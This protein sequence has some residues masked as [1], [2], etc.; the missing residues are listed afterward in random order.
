[1]YEIP[2]DELYNHYPWS[3]ITRHSYTS[4]RS[5]ILSFPTY[6]SMSQKRAPS[7]GGHLKACSQS[8]ARRSSLLVISQVP[9]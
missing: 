4:V 6:Q 9:N 3:S 5:P 7:P 2:S 8:P 1:M